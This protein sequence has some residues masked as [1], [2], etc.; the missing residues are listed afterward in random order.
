MALHNEQ[1]EKQ[2]ID[3]G[4]EPG[5]VRG[6]HLALLKSQSHQDMPK[7]LNILVSLGQVMLEKTFSYRNHREAEVRQSS[8]LTTQQSRCTDGKNRVQPSICRKTTS[9]VQ[10]I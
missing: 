9:R 2:S 10:V 5:L 7:S 3:S 1:S 6:D 4:L 8:L